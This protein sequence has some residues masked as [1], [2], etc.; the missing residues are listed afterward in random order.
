MVLINLLF[1]LKSI[2]FYHQNL[3]KIFSL[4]SQSFLRALVLCRNKNLVF[5]VIGAFKHIVDA[6]NAALI[7]FGRF[8]ISRD[9]GCKCKKGWVAK[10]VL[11]VNLHRLFL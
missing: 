5:E 4:S 11:L 10:Q 2:R 3:F 1:F 9:L 6:F 8:N 7:R